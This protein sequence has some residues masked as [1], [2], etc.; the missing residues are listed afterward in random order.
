MSAKRVLGMVLAAVLVLTGCGTG[1][2]QQA[3]TARGES[4][5]T[6]EV[7]G[8]FWEGQWILSGEPAEAE[9]MWS[10]AEYAEG[11]LPEAAGR[12]PGLR[13]S[14]ADASRYAVL[15]EYYSLHDGEQTREFF[16]TEYDT[17]T[18]SGVTESF[19]LKASEA[20]ETGNAEVSDA[21]SAL[22]E[23][24]GNIVGMDAVNGV[25]TFFVQI[26][27]DSG[28]ALQLTAVSTDRSGTVTKAAAL[29][30]A[31][32]ENGFRLSANSFPGECL[33][34]GAGRFYVSDPEQR[35]VYVLDS[36]GALLTKLEAGGEMLSCC[37]QL[38]DHTPVFLY[39]KGEQTALTA[40]DGEQAKILYRGE[41]DGGR[42][43]CFG[44]GGRIFY[45]QGTKL[46]AWNTADGSLRI[47]TDHFPVDNCEAFFQNTAGELL[48]AFWENGEQC[49][50]RL[51][52]E[53]EKESVKIELLT[54]VMDE[55]VS[56]CAAEYSKRHPGVEISVRTPD[57]AADEVFLNRLAQE[58]A[59]GSAPALLLL[60]RGQLLT[61]Q[62]KGLL[63]N[64]DGVL[65]D[66]TKAQIFEGVLENG[67][68]DGALYGIT[69]EATV[70]TLL[71]PEETW[72]GETWTLA[73]VEAL[74]SAKKEAEEFAEKGYDTTA[75]QMLYD[76]VL[77]DVSASPFLDAENGSCCFDSPE[78]EA[79][80]KLSK[81]YGKETIVN[82][83]RTEKE[84][85]ELLTEGKALAYVF[86]G[87]LIAFSRAMA[88][89][90]ENYR[91]V[92]YPSQSGSGSYLNFYGG[93][94]AVSAGAANREVID[95]FLL[96]LLN[97]QTQQR[98]GTDWVRKDALSGSVRDRVEI[99]GEKDPVPVFVK[100][101][102]EIIALSGRADG[103]SYLPEYLALLEKSVPRQT[104]W[105]TVTGIVLE[106]AAAYFSGDK[107]ARDVAAVI[108]N[109]V[110]LLLEE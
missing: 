5:G 21:L 15:T 102:T 9:N 32:S 45:L 39:T 88:S 34:D 59:D 86:D 37:G 71:V 105:D 18:M 65:P 31:L 74:L 109:R 97:A 103:T 51:K 42:R 64:L 41:W 96:Y 90:G 78:F 30:P 95:D 46:L 54:L 20:Q 83:S 80:L 13:F 52:D 10:V 62:E 57:G 22:D 49:L 4:V 70:S 3:E 92:G 101:G 11:F 107:S 28:E 84:R 23:M 68:V 2:A 82:D 104:Q 60:R 36:E 25:Y 14:C 1:E 100:G 98:Y 81:T 17:D 38:P 94:V 56:R 99:Y 73:D 87:G 61:L 26:Q 69:Y 12:T 79:V 19:S 72:S 8:D 44:D 48:I 40:F 66:E 85:A 6:K 89:L 55:Y 58:I 43:L 110:Q 108:Q 50:I 67:M 53:P 27:D 29:F 93:C 24:R 47:L 16:L 7:T 76:L 77:A 33:A 63:E 35:T 91:S 75:A 106:E